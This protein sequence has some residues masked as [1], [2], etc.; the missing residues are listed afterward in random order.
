MDWDS[1]KD[2]RNSDNRRIDAGEVSSTSTSLLLRLKE[3]EP[4]AWNQMAELY[5]PLVFHWARRAGLSTQDA[6]DVVQ[7]VF[8]TVARKMSDFRRDR[9]GD[10]F[11]AWLRVITRN[12]VGNALKRLQREDSPVGGTN[13]MREM[14]QVAEQ[15]MLSPSP[16][17]TD[18]S[19]LFQR[20]FSLIRSEFKEQTWQAFWRVVIDDRGAA[21]VAA[22]LDMSIN[23][24]YIA[25]S[26]VLC[27]LREVLGDPVE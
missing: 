14:A 6:E 15:G 20:A 16:L 1:V 3:L 2:S 13:A 24:V 11:R 18:C 26:R 17:E 27:R 23:A 9:G 25:K 12:K 22:E 7:E 4:E 19:G 5:G 21:D 8:Q 10:S